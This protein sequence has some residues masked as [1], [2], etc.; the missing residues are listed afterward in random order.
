M[1]FPVTQNVATSDQP[2]QNIAI[3]GGG[4]G[5][6]VTSVNGAPGPAITIAAGA[7]LNQQTV[8]NTIT[9][10]NNSAPSGQIFYVDG[11]RT[12]TYTATG[13]ILF[14]FKTI[15]A[16][17]AKVISNAD[18]GAKPYNI[19]VSPGAYAETVTLNSALLFNLT[20]TALANAGT[21]VQNTSITSLVSNATNTNLAN[22]IFSG[23]TFNGAINLSGDINN[24][25][26]GSTQILFSDCQFNAG[27]VT[28]FDVNNVNFYNCQIQG[29][30]ACTWTNVAFA[31]M[32]GP[33]GFI[34]G[35]TLHLVQNGGL[36]QPSQALGNYFLLSESKFFGT[37]TIDA[38]SEMDS[39]ES[40]FGSSSNVTNNGTIHSW[41]TNWGM[42]TTALIL[43]NGSTTRTRG[44]NF[45]LT[46]TVNAGASILYQG[47][48]GYT[49][50][51][52]ARWANP[53]PTNLRDAID[54]IA[55]VVGNPVAIP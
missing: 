47:L 22:C 1:V 8:G 3:V 54:R 42:A 26:F 28:L 49:P 30:A 4:G 45:T 20:F 21:A 39:L 36:N 33:E 19:L 43:N 23:F 14:P 25:N 18:N 6:T 11:Q 27:N 40:Y 7:G 29:A 13:N 2:T 41:A 50:A 55:N 37:M 53:Q 15:G 34:G 51:N 9:L 35:T 38:G 10:N 12:D 17:V 24:T 52:A 5:G 31:Y 16:A 48:W 46:P 32:S 44:D